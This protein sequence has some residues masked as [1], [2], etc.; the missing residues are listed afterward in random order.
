ML[1]IIN[2]SVHFFPPMDNKMEPAVILINLLRIEL[3]IKCIISAVRII[4]LLR[5]MV[6]NEQLVCTDLGIKKR[7][8]E[9]FL[10][11]TIFRSCTPTFPPISVTPE[12]TPFC[13]KPINHMVID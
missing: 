1:V 7:L 3:F 11:C 8:H 6:S 4:G 5:N 13:V 9:V 12:P 2:M 10:H